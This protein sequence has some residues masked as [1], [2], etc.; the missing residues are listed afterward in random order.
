MGP[1]HAM[2]ES[3]VST[4][5]LA[6]GLTVP[7]VYEKNSA[8][9]TI[10]NAY[11]NRSVRIDNHVNNSV[12]HSPIYNY[13]VLAEATYKDSQAII[14]ANLISDAV[15]RAGKSILASLAINYL[16][17]QFVG[18]KDIAIAYVFC[19]FKEQSG[20]GAIDLVKSI[21]SQLSIQSRLV[22]DQAGLCLV[23]DALRM[24]HEAHGSV[25]SVAECIRAMNKILPCFGCSFIIVDAMDEIAD[26]AREDFVSNLFQSLNGIN[27]RILLTF[28]P[29]MRIWNT[30]QHEAATMIKITKMEILAS[31]SDIEAYVRRELNGR[32]VF[33][34][35][36]EDA[37]VAAPSLADGIV[38]IIQERAKGMFLLPRFHVDALAEATFV[39]DVRAI[40]DRLPV[41]INQ[42][43]DDILERI[44]R[45]A[46][47]RQES[48]I[49]C[50]AKQALVWIAYS[51]ETLD[52]DALQFA[53][54]VEDPDD[55]PF[56][57]DASMP[58][59]R[60]VLFACAGLIICEYGVQRYGGGTVRFVHYTLQEYLRENGARHFKPGNG[61]SPKEWSSTV[62]ISFYNLTAMPP[63][64]AYFAYAI[65]HWYKHAEKIAPLPTRLRD[66]ILRLLDGVD[67]I[68]DLEESGPFVSAM[69]FGLKELIKHLWSTVDSFGMLRNGASLLRKQLQ[70]SHRALFQRRG[71]YILAKAARQDFMPTVQLLLD[72]SHGLDLNEQTLLLAFLGNDWCADVLAPCSTELLWDGKK[73]REAYPSACRKSATWIG[74]RPHTPEISTTAMQ[75]AARGGH[76]ACAELLHSAALTHVD[77]AVHE[78]R[79]MDLRTPRHLATEVGDIDLISS[80]RAQGADV[81][82]YDRWPVTPLHLACLRGHAQ[83]VSLLLSRGA[84]PNDTSVV[85]QSKYAEY[86]WIPWAIL[87]PLHLTMYSLARL[88]LAESSAKKIMDNLFRH[89]ASSGYALASFQ[90]PGSPRMYNPERYKVC[91]SVCVAGTRLEYAYS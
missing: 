43:Y 66:D 46:N 32:Q 70:G 26:A 22:N 24:Q 73:P 42:M 9:S 54:S 21:L 61:M 14:I 5:A 34:Q 41:Q 88:R 37:A 15:A 62:C 18:N 63:K 75:A 86:L 53:V 90:F 3:F 4:P 27:A 39:A 16:Q 12:N 51:Q 79:A 84:R 19:N 25:P 2:L 82:V 6:T 33:R 56:Y 45:V 23:L 29:I 91:V 20:Q 8:T 11:N 48:S 71:M 81:N 77:P 47:I 65:D 83:A 28:R 60:V 64:A 58:F 40:L 87:R 52:M 13:Q 74:F 67:E 72:R 76:S 36:L 30:V 10:T 7:Q 50:M 17:Q 44:Q 35:T 1:D 78:R 55:Q 85:W 80:I 69:A 38:E 31:S 49:L 59:P 57:L 89:G 68:D